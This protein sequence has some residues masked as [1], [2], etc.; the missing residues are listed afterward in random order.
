MQFEG[1]Y[2]PLVTPYHDDFS[3]NAPA[4]AATVDHL[5]NAGVHGIIVAGTTGEYYAQTTEERLDLMGQVKDLIAGRVPMIVGTGAIRT[6]DAITF[7]KAAADVGADALLI[8]TPP[9]AYPTGREI[10]LHALAIDNPANEECLAHRAPLK[11]DFI[12]V[13]IAAAICSQHHRGVVTS[14]LILNCVDSVPDTTVN[15]GAALCRFWTLVR[16]VLLNYVSNNVW[17]FSFCSSNR[18]MTFIVG[19]RNKKSNRGPFSFLSVNEFA[20]MPFRLKFN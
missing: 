19:H 8:A 4:L 20:G 2:T 18:P 9:Y 5:V 7:A 1:I 16:K 10:A 13:E 17:F 12:W 11:R 14:I 6:E 15:R 3:L